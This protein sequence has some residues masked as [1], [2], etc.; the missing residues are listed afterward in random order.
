M[1]ELH[2]WGR[3]SDVD[4]VYDTHGVWE[5]LG[6]RPRHREHHVQRHLQP[7]TQ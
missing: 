7:P 2:G 4:G 1:H 3:T 5:E 6:G